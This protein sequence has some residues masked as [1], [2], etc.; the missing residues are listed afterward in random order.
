MVGCRTKHAVPQDMSVP[1]LRVIQ[2]N[3]TTSSPIL[4]HQCEDAPCAA[5]CP[6]GALYHDDANQRIGIKPELCIGCRSCVSACPYGAID[7]RTHGDYRKVGDI[8]IAATQHAMPI[9]CD[10]CVDRDNGPACVEACPKDALAVYVRDDTEN[11]AVAP[12]GAASG[13]E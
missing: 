12:V 13:R 7:V 9:K 4:C 8:T 5:A 6:T 11:A 10:R 1:R 2:L 3:R